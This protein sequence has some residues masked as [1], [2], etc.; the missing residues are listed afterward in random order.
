MKSSKIKNKRWVSLVCLILLIICIILPGMPVIASDTGITITGVVPLR[1]SNVLVS[2]I[3]TSSAVISWDTNGGAVS[4]VFY[5]TISHANATD[6]AYQSSLDNTLVIMHSITLTG[7]AS[8][9]TC[10]FSVQSQ[11][12]INGILSVATS[13][14]YTFTTSGSSGSGGGV[15]ITT[16]TTPT[17]NNTNTDDNIGNYYDNH[18]G[19]GDIHSASDDGQ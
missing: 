5:D 13:S 19:T 8:G 7:L 9:T 15:I 17:T 10:H 2:G 6:Y 4:Q 3:T 1:I 11:A 18:P 12:K 16:T 14:D